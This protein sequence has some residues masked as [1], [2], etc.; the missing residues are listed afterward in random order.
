MSNDLSW[1]DRDPA[2]SGGI[3]RRQ[4]L[5]ALAAGAGALAAG[6]IGGGTMVSAQAAASP[7]T[8]LPA[9]SASG[10]DHIVVLMME[11]RSFDHYLG[12]LPGSDG[13]Q[14]GL[15]YADPAGTLHPTYHLTTYQGC[16]ENDPDHSY[17]GG[18]I[19]FN[20]GKCN[21]WL[22]DTANDIFC[23]G[24]YTA[25]D[26]AFHSQAARYWTTC[27]H[28]FAA[29]MGPTYPN[30][31]YMH[32]AQTDRMDDSTTTSTLPT[33]WDSLATAGVS[34][35]YYFS[36]VPFTALWGTKYAPISQPVSNFLAAC[37]AGT[38][39][40][41]SFVD[42]RFED[43]GSGTSG[44]DHPHADIRVGQSFLNQI[45]DAVTSGP[46]WAQ[47]VFVINYDEWGGFFD[48]VA[49]ATA[50]D[51]NPAN[52][53]RGFRVPALVISP[54]ARRNTVAHNTYDHTSVLKM[55]EWRWG[56][57][58]LTPR[59][60]AARNM[61]EVLDFSA[62][63]NL[64]AP[65]WNVPAVVPQACPVVPAAPGPA[66][67]PTEHELTWSAVRSLAQA[68]GFAPQRAVLAG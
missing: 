19:E 62:A 9:P 12:W 52:G 13:R 39:P 15:K 26:L 32:A 25:S 63:P 57:P 67:A 22:L 54:R 17:Q 4:V 6:G 53:L 55:I 28:Y 50:P 36:D 65:R 68:S 1:P 2:P 41:V 11:N 30:R 58:A 8:A 59:D 24:Y 21:G 42:P 64:T 14:A 37:A 40:A 23:I 61:A 29:T 38:L 18:R 49:P 7:A 10:I 43:E 27:D 5:G 56:L 51:A 34:H 33:I 46:A 35:N 47:T 48:H 45:Y 60:A 44:D 66:P 16:G 3:P 20:G 31:F